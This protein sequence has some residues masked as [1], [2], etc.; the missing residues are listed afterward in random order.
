MRPAD[1]DRTELERFLRR[2]APV[3]PYALADLDDAL[4]P[5]VRFYA[6][7][8]SDGELEALC[9]VLDELELPIV[10]AVAPPGDPA[11]L[12]LLRELEPSLPERFYANLPVGGGDA[13]RPAR[14]LA[15]RGVHAKMWLAEPAALDCAEPAGLVSLGPE[16]ADELA[17][18]YATRAYAPSEREGR[19]FA[20]SMLE[21][22]PW[23]GVR[24]RGQLVAVAGLH[25]FSRRYGV[26]ALANVA[27]APERRGRGLARAICARLARELLRHVPLVGLNCAVDNAP[28]RRCYLGLGFRDALRYEEAGVTRADAPV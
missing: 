26:A 5:D 15:P 10:Y 4:F 25:V 23:L 28:A 9:L 22:F 24:E 7:R 17:E 14:A 6:T 12:A 8:K 13:L 19:F 18:F 3:H 20:R 1:V 27:T 16:H 21:P 11:T 2:S